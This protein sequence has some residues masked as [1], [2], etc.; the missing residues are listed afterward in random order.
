[1]NVTSSIL[2]ESLNVLSYVYLSPG[3]SGPPDCVMW[4][5]WPIVLTAHLRLLILDVQLRL[6]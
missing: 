2:I 1:M 3:E 6:W 4:F 5:Y